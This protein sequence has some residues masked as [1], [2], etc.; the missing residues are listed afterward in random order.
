MCVLC[1]LDYLKSSIV[2]LWLASTID[3]WL[4]LAQWK[5]W[6][7]VCPLALPPAPPGPQVIDACFISVL[8]HISEFVCHTLF[9]H[10]WPSRRFI[11]FLNTTGDTKSKGVAINLPF[12]PKDD[13]QYEK[14]VIK[15]QILQE[16]LLSGFPAWSHPAF[17]TP[18][19]FARHC[20]LYGE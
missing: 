5:M 18:D 11:H 16:V 12:A 15:S 3:K 2:R 8:P 9:T 17:C 19:N 1:M 20:N 13:F 10:M 14:L 7:A 4:R 6:A